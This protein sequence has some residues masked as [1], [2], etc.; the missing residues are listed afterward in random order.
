MLFDQFKIMGIISTTTVF[1]TAGNP[2]K[3]DR[4]VIW[5][6][7]FQAFKS[8]PIVT[9]FDVNISNSPATV[10]STFTLNSGPIFQ[11]TVDFLT[12]GQDGYLVFMGTRSGI[13]YAKRSLNGGVPAIDLRGFTIEGLDLHFDGYT[14]IS[15]HGPGYWA[16]FRFVI[17]GKFPWWWWSRKWWRDDF[18]DWWRRRQKIA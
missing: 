6:S 17:R 9:I 4:F 1:A 5:A 10:G 18:L 13:D 8:P 3:P 11:Q 7:T 14:V 16:T 12:N 15:G 2:P